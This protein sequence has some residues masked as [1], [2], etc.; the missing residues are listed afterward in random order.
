MCYPKSYR[1]RMDCSAIGFLSGALRAP[2]VLAAL[3]S[4]LGASASTLS[5]LDDAQARI[6]YGF[7]T[8]D[9]RAIESVL[10]EVASYEVDAQL[11]PFKSYQLAYGHWK[12]AQVHAQANAADAHLRNAGIA[13]KA[14]KTCVEHARTA[15]RLDQRMAEAYAL[16]AVCDDMPLGFVRLAGLT[17]SCARSRP[18][19]SAL[20]L[21]PENP[22]VLLIEAMCAADKDDAVGVARWRKV[23][24]A[25]ASSPSPSAG[26]PDWGEA[27]ALVMLGEHHLQRGEAL[28]AREALER[29]LVLAP[30]YDA[31]RELLGTAAGRAR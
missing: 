9:T 30:D 4:P 25:F 22:R 13:T 7:L 17:G 14:A 27:E 10:Q 31:P 18:L 11:A 6:Q 28:A 20:S 29:A 16:E 24:D 12:L 15:R 3:L 8:S 26:K 5:E 2:L 1:S 19:R 21:E 23:V